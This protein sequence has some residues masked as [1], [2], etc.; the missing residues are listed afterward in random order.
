MPITS[1]T[2][3]WEEPSP[4][5]LGGLAQGLT[6][7]VGGYQ[8]QK[9][10]KQAELDKLL[11]IAVQMGIVSPAKKGDEGAVKYGGQYWKFDK[12]GGPASL[13]EALGIPGGQF[14][15]DWA[16]YNDYMK[17]QFSASPQ[18]LTDLIITNLQDDAVFRKM[19]PE[20][21]Q[22]YV[23]GLTNSFLEAFRRGGTGGGVGF[24]PAYQAAGIPPGYVPVQINKRTK[25]GKEYVEP[26]VVQMSLEEFRKSF[27]SST[28]KILNPVEYLQEAGLPVDFNAL[29]TAERTGEAVTTTDRTPAPQVSVPSP[30]PRSQTQVPAQQAQVPAQQ[31]GQSNIIP[32]LIR[33]G[34]AM[35]MLAPSVAKY[36]P[37]ALK[38][39]GGFAKA[40]P[41]VLGKALGPAYIGAELG[42]MLGGGNVP[43][44]D[45]PLPFVSP[46][47]GGDVVDQRMGEAVRRNAFLRWIALSRPGFL[48]GMSQ[49]E[50][51]LLQGT[52]NLNTAQFNDLINRGQ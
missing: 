43:F 9:E 13:G 1:K 23:S 42:S 27:D 32:N 19:D 40:A 10:R 46:Y 35:K 5:A 2:Q 30:T 21:Q 4:N 6:A 20:A 11:P 24:G 17:A 52:N 25:I 34:V 18:A 7:L 39:V 50:R 36:G 15:K 26:G 45:S 3:L 51:Q 33:S 44:T 29:A 37:T 48:G 47:K 49:Q 28:M 16:D 14:I 22:A 12:A 8:Q 31:A 41:R 38:A